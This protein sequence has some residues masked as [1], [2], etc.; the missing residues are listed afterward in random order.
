M[1]NNGDKKIRNVQINSEELKFLNDNNSES[2]LN[3]ILRYK[4]DITEISS[5]ELKETMVIINDFL[6]YLKNKELFSILIES[7]NLIFIL[8]YSNEPFNSINEQKFSIDIFS[9]FTDSSNK[10]WILVFEHKNFS[11][12]II[13]NY[14][15]KLTLEEK[16]KQFKNKIERISRY[17][18]E[19]GKLN[20]QTFVNV[21]SCLFIRESSLDYDDKNN[22][23]NGEFINNINDLNIFSRLHA[24]TLNDINLF[25]K[26][27]REHNYLASFLSEKKN[28]YTFIDDEIYG[29]INN[30]IHQ[31]NNQGSLV[32][33]IE[34]IPGSGKTAM[35][36]E[37]LK[38][39]KNS[40]LLILNEKF[41]WDIIKNIKQDFYK[42]KILT[43]WRTVTSIMT[44]T[45]DKSSIFL[46][47][48]ECQRLSAKRPAYDL[49]NISGC[50]YQIDDLKKWV[51]DGLNLILL[52]DNKQ[53]IN[54]WDYKIDLNNDFPNR[55]NKNGKWSFKLK[56]G[57]YRL[58]VK[59][60]NKIEYSLGFTDN[61]PQK[62][63]SNFYW[64][65]FYEPKN[66]DFFMNDYKKDDGNIKIIS[67]VTTSFMQKKA[68]DDVETIKN[69]TFRRFHWLYENDRE[70]L[71]NSLSKM[72]NL[73]IRKD[74]Y[75]ILW[76]D[77]YELISREID[78][79]YLYI[80]LTKD[81]FLQNFSQKEWNEKKSRLYVL[82][83]RATKKLHIY[84]EDPE[85][86]EYC[87][88]RLDE[89]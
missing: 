11:K 67:K 27:S 40:Y 60:I 20:H 35:A 24:K 78:E 81:E 77:P 39:I 43:H 3:N 31:N 75:N 14:N 70:K 33:H 48:D 85:L 8:E 54:K 29:H 72:G 63:N 26:S 15:Y 30:E 1:K 76:F 52:G 88:K 17:F 87:K 50:F 25:L 69:Y 65:E 61:R 2:S 44:K 66:L 55:K 56:N 42:D 82:L 53:T 13:K 71:R 4:L 18:N 58:P 86:Y 46:I 34:G 36:I 74:N 59:F 83:T 37:F 22:Y 89:C 19:N 16:K 47:V 7:N 38:F 49:G 10:F 57:S 80:K 12:M 32:F 23:L 6:T 84:F 62:N 21:L 5:E 51:N 79:S 9:A 41:G 64:I 28:I 73:D 68:P 45:E